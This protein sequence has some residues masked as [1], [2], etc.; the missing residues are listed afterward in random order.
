MNYL[1]WANSYLAVF[2]GFYWFFLRKETFFQLNRGYL[3]S[4]I[5]LSFILPILDMKGYFFPVESTQFFYILG[6]EA[7]VNWGVVPPVSAWS[8]WIDSISGISIVVLIYGVGCVYALIKLLYRLVLINGSISEVKS[9]RDLGHGT[10]EEA[11]RVLESSPKWVPGK[12]DGQAVRVQ[13][14]LPIVLNLDSDTK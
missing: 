8:N 14:T 13:Y 3:L 4:G 12:K 7:Q 9:V 5:F 2:Y 1:F 6:F 10:G 11:A